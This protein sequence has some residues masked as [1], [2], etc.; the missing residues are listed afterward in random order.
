M[1]FD[2]QQMAPNAHRPYQMCSYELPDAIARPMSDLEAKGYAV[3][4]LP[5]VA[6]HIRRTS[7]YSFMNSLIQPGSIGAEIGV[8]FGDG[9]ER[10][11]TRAPGKLYLV[12]PWAP[13][14]G[15]DPWTDVSIAEMERRYQIVR[16]RFDGSHAVEVVRKKSQDWFADMPDASLD[17]IYL[18]GDHGTEAVMCDLRQSYRVVKPGGHIFGDDLHTS[19]WNTHIEKAVKWF[20]DNHK[21]TVI[22][23][24]SDPFCIRRD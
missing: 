4:L 1:K 13:T 3:T 9:A 15:Y 16:N 23:S 2:I 5:M 7:G 22:W 24:E 21:V 10:I 8:D 6:A 18:D 14:D 20:V 12:D 17:W 19:K 11:L